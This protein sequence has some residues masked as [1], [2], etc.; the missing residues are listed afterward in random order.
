MFVSVFI[1]TISGGE[2]KENSGVK[3]DSGNKG[4]I[5]SEGES[6]EVNLNSKDAENLNFNMDTDYVVNSALQIWDFKDTVT[7]DVIQNKKVSY[8]IKI[9]FL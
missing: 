8:L 4:V 7:F 1:G 3:Y 2:I 9:L 5:V 6:S